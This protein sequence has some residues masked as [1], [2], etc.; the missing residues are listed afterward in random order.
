MAGVPG[1][2]VVIPTY[3]RA[4]LLPEALDSVLAQDWPELEIVVVDDGSTDETSDL[5]TDYELRRPEAMRVIRQENAGESAARNAG[6]SA[7]R[8]EYVALLDSDNRWAPGKLRRQ[9]AL[10]EA[11][12][13]VDFTFTAYTNFG[14]SDELVALGRW[15][16]SRDYAI[17][18]LLIGCCINT[19]TVVAKRSCLLD[20]G[21]FDRSLQCCQDH[22]LWLRIAARGRHIRYLPESLTEYRVH[23]GGV[24]SDA[25]L[26]SANTERVFL[27]LFE[28]GSLPDRFQ[29]DRAFYISRCYLNSAARYLSAGDGRQAAA[30]LRRAVRARPASIRPGWLRMY[31]KAA[32]LTL[33][34]PRGPLAAR[35]SAPG[36]ALQ[37]RRRRNRNM[38]QA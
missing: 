2:S 13:R 16:E 21:L 10:F 9:M 24:S 3:N 33:K 7:A 37:S 15:D 31:A 34:P 28:S 36:R 30:A 11:D 26:V 17:E 12:P 27:R 8:H 20:S 4:D 5:L 29:V 14:A 23:A 35:R 6:I 1:V 19:S 32:W 22:D 25:K 18:Q 38:P